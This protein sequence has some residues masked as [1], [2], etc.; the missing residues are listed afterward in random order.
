MGSKRKPPPDRGHYVWPKTL[1]MPNEDLVLVYLD[2]NHWITLAQADAGHPKGRAFRDA[3]GCLTRGVENGEVICPLTLSTCVEMLKINR[4]KGRSDLRRIMESL[5]GFHYIVHRGVLAT[6]EFEALFDRDIG[7]NPHPIPPFNYLVVGILR[8][9]GRSGEIK[10]LDAED[11]DVTASVRERFEGG[12]RE[13]DQIL[14]WGRAELNRSLL[15]GQTGDRLADLDPSEYRPDLVLQAYNDEAADEE[16]WARLLDEHPRVRQ[17][18]LMDA[19]AAREAVRCGDIWGELLYV[20]RGVRSL[21]DVFPTPDDTRKAFGALPSFDVSVRLKALMHQNPQHRWRNNHIH[22]VN[23]LACALPY[24]QI[25]LADREMAA[26]I[27]RA[28]ICQRFNVAV[29]SSLAGLPALLEER[30]R[31]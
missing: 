6:H 30:I 27:E 14:E 13:F 1:L 23:A 26:L 31:R 16:A 8:A 20:D 21:E 24:C 22:D 15:D 3:L 11:Q 10:V 25:V 7:P 29:L 18:R 12:T 17:G 5:S 4:R 28:Q 19:V 2:L 9:L